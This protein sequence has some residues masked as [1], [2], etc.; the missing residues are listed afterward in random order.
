MKDL[1]EMLPQIIVPFILGGI[2][3]Y[4]FN[5]VSLHQSH[6]DHETN[7]FFY[8]LVGF[9]IQTAASAIR[10]H[11]VSQYD[12]HC[13]SVVF[14]GIIC[15]VVILIAF[16]CAK[17][18]RSSI[19]ASVRAKLGIH[20]TFEKNYWTDLND[21]ERGTRVMAHL[22]DS[23]TYIEGELRYLESN[24]RF[25][26]IALA[27]YSIFQGDMELEDRSQDNSMLISVDTQKCDFIELKY[28]AKSRMLINKVI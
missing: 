26:Q 13:I 23:D 2:F 10:N 12:I 8:Y 14:Y 5:S 24:A 6:D 7:W 4:T 27:N 22:N 9:I 21:V 25:P 28:G 17:L 16:V 1:I 15:V 19:F 20:T 3:M 18:F 11:L